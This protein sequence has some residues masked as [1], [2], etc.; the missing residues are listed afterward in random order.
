MTVQ[1]ARLHR[2]ARL[3]IA[4]ALMTTALLFAAPT[5]PGQTPAPRATPAAESFDQLYE[6]GQRAN[7]SMRTLTARFTESTTSTLLVKPLV[8]RGT[9]AVERPSRVILNYLEPERRVVL[10]DDNKM[11]LT[12]PTP[13]VLDVGAAMK[14]VQRYFVEGSAAD[15]RRQFDIDDRQTND[16]PGQYHVLMTPKQKRIRET[17]ASLELWVDRETSLMSAMRMAFANGD[18]KTMT[19]DQVTPNAPL[20]AG[21]FT[22]GR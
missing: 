22:P 12:W 17:L 20:A 7:A 13:Q 9:L 5:S 19:F 8:A 4:I 14:R 3:A 21:T 1:R 18:T 2:G 11:T 15:L 6:R 16:P 10:I